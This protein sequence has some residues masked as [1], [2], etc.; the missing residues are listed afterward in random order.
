[1]RPFD[2]AGAVFYQQENWMPAMTDDQLIQLYEDAT[3]ELQKRQEAVAETR[4]ELRMIRQ[5]MKTR[6]LQEPS[7]EPQSP[8]EEAA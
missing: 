5:S 6:G 7:E 4:T 8:Q 1:M 2:D 3:R